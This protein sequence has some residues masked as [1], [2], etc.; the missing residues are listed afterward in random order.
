MYSDFNLHTKIGCRWCTSDLHVAV[1]ATEA[2]VPPFHQALYP[3]VEEMC[4]SVC[5]QQVTACSILAAAVASSSGF[6]RD[7]NL[8]NM[9][10][11]IGEVVHNLTAIHIFLLLQYTSLGTTVGQIPYA[12]PLTCTCERQDLK[13]LLTYF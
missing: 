9:I 1:I 2:F 11:T 3:N 5:S 13:L 7:R 6:Q 10:R 8:E 4:V 12:N